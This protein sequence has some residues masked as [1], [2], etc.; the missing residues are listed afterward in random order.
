MLS[1]DFKNMYIE[2]LTFWGYHILLENQLPRALNLD[3]VPSGFRVQ[4]AY[5]KWSFEMF[6]LCR[7]ELEEKSADLML[8]FLCVLTQ[9]P[10]L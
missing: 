8:S 3:G 7:N 9:L 5:M 2:Q 10:E 1:E 4:W 6:F